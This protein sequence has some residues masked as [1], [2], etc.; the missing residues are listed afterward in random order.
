VSVLH[1]RHSVSSVSDFLSSPVFDLSL[2][3]RERSGN[4]TGESELPALAAFSPIV[5]KSCD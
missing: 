3:H 1:R 2:Q 4:A 5:K